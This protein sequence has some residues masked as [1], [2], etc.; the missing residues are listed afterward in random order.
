M[1]SVNSVPYLPDNVMDYGKTRDET[2]SH[3][4]AASLLLE[5]GVAF[6]LMLVAHGHGVTA[7][8]PC[9]PRQERVN[10]SEAQ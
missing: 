5:L 1:T 8:G 6:R 7:D 3:L 2:G 9:G 10:S 4:L